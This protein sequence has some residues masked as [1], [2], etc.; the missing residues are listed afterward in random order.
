MKITLIANSSWYIFNFRTSLIKRLL[1]QGHELIIIAPVDEYSK[2]I[3]KMDVKFIDWNL[4]SSS[5]SLFTEPISFFKLI[6]ILKKIQTDFIFSFTP[7]ANI[8][9][10]LSLYLFKNNIKFLPNISGLGTSKDFNFLLKIV[11]YNFY[12][13]AFKNSKKIFFQNQDDF[14]IFLSNN[15]IK[16]SQGERIPGSG[17]NLDYFM[18]RKSINNTNDFLFVGRLLYAKGLNEYINATKYLKETYEDIRIFIVGAP[19]SNSK[20]GISKNDLN[21]LT[22][23]KNI[24][25]L[26][27]TDDIRGVLEKIDLV[28]LPSFYGEGVPRSLL[29]AASMGIPV[30]TTDHPG[31]RDVIDDNRTGYLCLPQDENSLISKIESFIKMDL[32][33]RIQMGNNA[34]QKMESEFSE[35]LVL[36]AY[37]KF[38]VNNK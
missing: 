24:N 7:K 32:K 34:R 9:S 13:I 33:S 19:A 16:K 36:N 8:Y 37:T 38:I 17:V 1:D 31:C 11:L 12:K 35:E 5:L 2:K 15:L 10:G 20:Q 6:R 26:G 3:K 14:N 30:I 22:N 4:N 28:V 25:Y 21:I 23:D 27:V 18:Q 29:E